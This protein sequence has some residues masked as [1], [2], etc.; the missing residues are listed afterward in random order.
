MVKVEII[1][2]DG[3][4]RFVHEL[5]I[6]P[7]NSRA[8]HDKLLDT[9][10][11]GMNHGSFREF[12]TLKTLKCRSMCVGDFIGIF[13]PSGQVFYQVESVGFKMVSPLYMSNFLSETKTAISQ[14]KPPFSA[15]CD[16]VWN[17]QKVDA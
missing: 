17:R 7:V 12:E 6:P 4:V 14:G 1:Y 2:G 8:E 13:Y 9:V 15:L 11:A 3:T 5:D 16:A 10:W